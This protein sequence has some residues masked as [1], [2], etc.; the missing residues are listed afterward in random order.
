MR[1]NLVPLSFFLLILSISPVRILASAMTDVFTSD[2]F[3]AIM[4]GYYRD[5]TGVKGSASGAEYSG[6]SGIQANKRIAFSVAEEAGMVSTVSGGV[7][8][9]V[10]VNWHNDI[11][12]TRFIEVYGSHT[13]YTSIGT[14]YADEGRGELLGTLYRGET[15]LSFSGEYEYVGIRS[16]EL[17]A[18]LNWIEITWEEA[19]TTVEV[20]SVSE[21]I[22][23]GRADA[24]PTYRFSKP[25]YATYGNGL[26]LYV[27]DGEKT[28]LHVAQASEQS[29]S[30]G[31]VIPAGLEGRFGEADGIPALEVSVMPQPEKSDKTEAPVVKN[32][33][34]LSADSASEYVLL[35]NVSIDRETALIG[36]ETGTVGYE[37]RFGAQIPTTGSSSRFDME[38]IVGLNGGAVVVYPI[39]IRERQSCPPPSFSLEGG[40]Y[41]GSQTILISGS[42]GTAIRYAVNGTSGA[43]TSPVEI[44]LPSVQGEVTAYE[45]AAV[46]TLDGY[47]DSGTAIGKYLIRGNETMID[48]NYELV[49]DGN[50]LSERSTVVF[51]T[52][53]EGSGTWFAMSGQAYDNERA[54]YRTAA[55]VEVNDG[56]TVTAISPAVEALTV[57][58]KDGGGFSFCDG[59]R[60]YLA[61]GEE[62]GSLAMSPTLTAPAVW[63]LSFES[64]GTA[65]LTTKGEDAES[66]VVMRANYDNSPNPIFTSIQ[67]GGAA[68]NIRLFAKSSAS[69]VSTAVSDGPSISVVRG[70]LILQ[71]SATAPLDVH[72]HNAGG[73]LVKSIC[74]S[75]KELQIADIPSGFYIVRVGETAA[76]VIIP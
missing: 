43:G 67:A 74:S 63:H 51:A 64:D 2:S 57:E 38:A 25:L 6:R 72:I 52:Y 32:A 21:L 65:V 1:N 53:S 76:K 23:K 8:T 54:G 24:S 47:A 37:D 10:R 34:E 48:D 60:S 49:S 20:S 9:G 3:K 44:V 28:P 26:D 7:C 13:P 15:E 4:S 31:H 55:I 35:E 69:S 30:N 73:Q 12:A 50:L 17:T 75:E 70:R 33:G 58:C 5:F 66:A 45:V 71:S 29:I 62:G 36:D 22:T 61:A 40:V 56:T 68:S 27:R 14:L 59:T 18:I 46:A 11:A 19:P 39:S 41:D 42:A 16:G